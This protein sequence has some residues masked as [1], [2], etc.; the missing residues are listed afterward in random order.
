MIRQYIG[1]SRNYH[2]HDRKTDRHIRAVNNDIVFLQFL[3]NGLAAFYVFKAV[4][5]PH[6]GPE[7]NLVSRLQKCRIFQGNK[8]KKERRKEKIG[9][10]SG[11]GFS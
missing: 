9:Y 1:V 6:C 11:K 2:L 8:A 3:A 4:I 7:W 5:V 10:L